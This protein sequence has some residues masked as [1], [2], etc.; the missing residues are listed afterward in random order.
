MKMRVGIVVHDGYK[1]I[2]NAYGTTRLGYLHGFQKIGTQ[3]WLVHRAGLLDLIGGAKELPL[4]WLT[5]DDYNYLDEET[6]EA[7]R[8]CPHIVQVNT[9]FEGMEE[10]HALFGAPSPKVPDET[11]AKIVASKPGFVWCS[12][13]E[14]YQ[15]FYQG[16]KDAGLKVVSLPWACDSTK[17]ADRTGMGVIDAD[18]ANADVAFVGGYRVYKEPQYEAYLWPYEDRLKVWGY[19]EWP[20]CYRG[21]LREEDERG[22]YR[23]ATV[24]PTIS[25]PQFAATGDTVER[26]F[27]ILGSGG[28]TVFDPVPSYEYLFEPW[29]ALIPRNDLEYRELMEEALNN[30]AVNQ[31]FRQRGR[32][33]VLSRHCYHH[34]AQKIV[35]ELALC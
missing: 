30:P 18:V 21:V 25:E 35:E 4:L 8:E 32:D 34:R 19:S 16:W 29:E 7:V 27:K 3:P 15:E 11:L 5:C 33:A 14:P 31:L 26:P 20:R 23:N 12:A 13:P 6:L 24:C 17:Y 28:L 2:S 10:L 22:L 9:W 1:F